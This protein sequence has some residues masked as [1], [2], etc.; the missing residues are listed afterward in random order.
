MAPTPRS[1]SLP[2]NPSLPSAALARAGRNE[3]HVSRRCLLH[4]IPPP[5]PSGKPPRYLFPVRRPHGRMCWLRSTLRAAGPAG[6]PR[7]RPRYSRGD[8]RP[9]C[10]QPLGGCCGETWVKSSPSVAG[11]GGKACFSSLLPARGELI[12]F[13]H[14]TAG[15][16]P[17]SAR[18][19]RQ[20]SCCGCPVSKPGSVF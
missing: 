15:S 1:G 6:S 3:H 4:R 13:M 10:S 14:L 12:F 9:C 16:H 11:S 2:S 5:Q 7:S 20:L 8:R 18:A 19:Q 17:G